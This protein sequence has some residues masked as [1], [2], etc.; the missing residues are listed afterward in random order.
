MEV[1]SELYGY[2]MQI[3]VPLLMWNT[4]RMERTHE[5]G[6]LD[7]GHFRISRPVWVW[8]G[9][10]IEFRCTSWDLHQVRCDWELKCYSSIQHLGERRTGWRGITKIGTWL[11]WDANILYWMDVKLCMDGGETIIM[12]WMQVRQDMTGSKTH[13]M[14]PGCLRL[15][16]DGHEMQFSGPAWR[17]DMTWM[18]VRCIYWDLHWDELRPGWMWDVNITPGLYNLDQPPSRWQITSIKVPK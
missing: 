3:Y 13:I 1:R 17:W 8:D 14:I 6:S 12:R 2:Q 15:D 18:E 11:G 4:I 10:W 5:S 7:W 16:L 9:T